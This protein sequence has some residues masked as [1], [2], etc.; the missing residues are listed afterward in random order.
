MSPLPPGHNKLIFANP[1]SEPSFI[2]I[3]DTL[4]GYTLL[5]LDCMKVLEVIIDSL[6]VF[7]GLMV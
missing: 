3:P 6:E 7:R 2:H 5:H 4:W 1:N